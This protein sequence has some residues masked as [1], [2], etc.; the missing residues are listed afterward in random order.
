MT[1]PS[2]HLTSDPLPI[3]HLIVPLE[4]YIVH[5]GHLLLD[6]HNVGPWM[7]MM[8]RQGWVEMR[9]W[10]QSISQNG[11]TVTVGIGK[12]S[13]THAIISPSCGRLEVEEEE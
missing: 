12:R 9:P 11:N 6:S 4:M 1:E 10:R 2:H 3:N 13:S 7:P 8:L 5:A